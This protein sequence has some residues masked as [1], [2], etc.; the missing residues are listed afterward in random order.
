M[1]VNSVVMMVMIPCAASLRLCVPALLMRAY[2]AGAVDC[3]RKRNV[4]SF[5]SAFIQ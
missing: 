1:I 3:S 2:C 5:I 4:I